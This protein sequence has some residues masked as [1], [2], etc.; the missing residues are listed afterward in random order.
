[1]SWVAWPKDDG[2][3]L[4]RY[5]LPEASDRVRT[6][7]A[8]AD[9]E[10]RGEL[11]AVAREIY[12]AL[13]IRDI[14]W[15]RAR[16]HP[17]DALQ[18][19]RPPGDILTGAGDGT[20]LD[21]ALLFAGVALGKELLP[22]VVVLE[23][24][25]LVAVSRTTERRK[26][27]GSERRSAE[28]DWTGEGLLTNSDKLKQMVDEGRYVLVEC[29]G[30][31]ASEGALPATLPE[32]RGRDDGRLSWAEAVRA[33]REQLEQINRPL[34]F[35]V[36]V[37]VLQDYSRFEPF[38]PLG[39]GIAALKPDL[40]LRFAEIF[41]DYR[42]VGGRERQLAALDT[43]AA[44]PN[45][46]YLLLTGQAGMGKT[47]LLV[48]WIRR[49][50]L[51][52]DVQ[53]VYHFIS[54]QYGT[55]ARQDVMASLVS[56]AAVAWGSPVDPGMVGASVIELETAWLKLLRAKP[57]QEVIVVLDGV[58]EAE[59]AGWEVP[60][61]LLPDT[62]P[63]KVHVVVSART[64]A[65]RDWGDR[66]GLR[67]AA[68]ESVERFDEAGVG[69][70]LAA[71]G[72]PDWVR[73]P[74]P[75]AT[76]RERTDGDPFYLRLLVEALT[77][78]EVTSP[79]DLE[80]HPRQLE[81]YLT[82]WWADLTAPASDPAVQALLGYL[83]V[84]RGPLARDELVGIDTGDA[85][86]G[87]TVD[88]A[89]SRVGRFVVGNPRTG[90]ALAHW[91]LQEF[92]ER[93]LTPDGCRDYAR[94]LLAWCGR[95][96][97]HRSRYALVYGPGQYLEQKA[98]EDLLEVTAL[99]TDMVFQKA[100]IEEADDAA[101]LFADLAHLLEELA[102]V[103]PP[104]T[105][106][107][108]LSA[109]TGVAFEAEDARARW[110]QP[111]RLVDL[112][113]E[114]EAAEAFRR[115]R[116][117][118][119]QPVGQWWDAAALILAW[120]SAPTHPDAARELLSHTGG[121]AIWDGL[122]VLR[123][124]VRAR[125]DGLPE[126]VLEMWF[127]PHTLPEVSDERMATAALDRLGGAPLYE[128]GIS[129]L[130]PPDRDPVFTRGAEAGTYLAEDDAPTLV[131]FARDAPGPGDA[132]LTRYINLFA[133]NPY[134]LYRNRSLL[135]VLAAVVCL[136]LLYQSV[137]HALHL[138][139]SAFAPA[140]VR[141]SEFARLAMLAQRAASGDAGAQVDIEDKRLGAM[142]QAGALG[143]VRGQG[144]LWGHNTRRL[145]AH[146]EML[147]RVVGDT[148]EAKEW[149][150]QAVELPFGYAGYRAPA[151]LALAEAVAVAAPG[152]SALQL[153]AL[154]AALKS[155]HNIQE[156]AFCA[157]TTARVTT[158]MNWWNS[159]P[160]DLPALVATFADDPAAAQFSPQHRLGEQFNE[161]SHSD[162]LDA[163]YISHLTTPQEI[164]GALGLPPLAVTQLNENAQPDTVL[165]PDAAFAPFVAAYLSARIVAADLPPAEQ[166]QLLRLLVPSAAGDATELD[167]VLGRLITVLPNLT[168]DELEDLTTVL[169]SR[170][171]LEPVGQWAEWR[172]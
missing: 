61:G 63:A 27:T 129:G 94:R 101:G 161:R 123:D 118:G 150:H 140:G 69:D 32:G 114:G 44:D 156:P 151:C 148:A 45:H 28:G 76:L 30:F 169:E 145:A 56:Q 64:M 165:L 99:L 166:A 31:A 66:L 33:G 19:V 3:G 110:L 7:S 147:A 55:A 15:A 52:S 25:A 146:A 120:A 90:V 170:Q 9:L 116:L 18:I 164:A 68:T 121:D 98:P 149:L 86:S 158:L 172:P 11:D 144:D 75:L 95:W 105:T 74:G 87:F 103:R 80:R 109:L 139:E 117:L 73:A 38:D 154:A 127:P 153:A 53:V 23:G 79:A 138:L 6:A 93:A 22:L 125:L 162:H 163:T 70:V 36:D 39:Q 12:D 46:R 124:R 89:L 71:A 47:A 26:A 24:H 134:A 14:R 104:S 20:C 37:A 160:E 43:F 171:T 96:R 29:T 34:L 152:D 130:P 59:A 57:S 143:A 17:D 50:G 88:A 141:F 91:R 35:A 122:R 48:E 40:R 115:L 112:I 142:N 41:E 82:G 5:V 92:A 65:G 78:G 137:S 8:P 16:Y 132:L 42:V 119:P 77:R 108:P 13:A 100:R 135:S 72:V 102:R 51:R 49:L 54:R 2:K 107:Q 10:A 60:R 84:A 1:M 4:S 21:L 83:V 159:V 128:R 136:P 58:D 126:P 113:A 97:D 133:A 81:A 85:L 155:A 157:L 106:R 111:D 67:D 167:R 62:L 131:A 168:T